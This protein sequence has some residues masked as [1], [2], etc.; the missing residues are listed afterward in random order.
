MIKILLLCKVKI[1]ETD[2]KIIK[3]LVK[4]LLDEIINLYQ[5]MYMLRGGTAI[6]SFFLMP[7]SVTALLSLTF[8]VI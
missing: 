8:E 7:C 3:I 5:A 2:F 1:I 6:I 4:A